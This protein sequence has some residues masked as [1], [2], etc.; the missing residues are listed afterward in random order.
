MFFATGNILTIRPIDLYSLEGKYL[1]NFE[2]LLPWLFD[3]CSQKL[4]LWKEIPVILALVSHGSVCCKLFKYFSMTLFP[5][6]RLIA[7][8]CLSFDVQKFLVHINLVVKFVLGA[9]LL[10]SHRRGLWD[11]TFE[12]QSCDH[13]REEILA[14]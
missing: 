8:F 1:I 11:I 9:I 5:Y 14:W 3:D 4:K 10:N 6:I 12:K 7:N 2:I 13:S